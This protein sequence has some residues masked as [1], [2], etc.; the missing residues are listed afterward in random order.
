[1]MIVLLD[2]YSCDTTQSLDD[3]FRG[4]PL[5]VR[6]RVRVRVRAMGK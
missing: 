1:V 6:V 4:K 2:F 5:L 3:L